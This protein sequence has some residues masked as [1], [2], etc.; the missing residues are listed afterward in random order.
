MENEIFPEYELR[1]E[2][3]RRR[4]PWLQPSVLAE[5]RLPDRSWIPDWLLEA[6]LE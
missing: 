3:E 5:E 2:L 4:N 1:D 6:I